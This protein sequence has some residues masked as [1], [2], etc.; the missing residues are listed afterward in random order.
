MSRWNGVVTTQIAPGGRF[1]GFSPRYRRH[2][3]AT[4]GGNLSVMIEAYG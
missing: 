2:I 3:A 4:P 1:G